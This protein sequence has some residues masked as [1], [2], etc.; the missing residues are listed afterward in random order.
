MYVGAA[1]VERPGNVV[2]CRHEHAVGMLVAESASDAH[3]FAVDGLACQLQGV[4]LHGVLGDGGAVTPQLTERVE[5]GAEGDSALTAQ[6]GD[7][8]F[9][10]GSRADHAVDAHFGAADVV[11]FLAQPL[12]DGG[13]A[14]DL[15]LHQL[16]LRALQLVGSGK[17]VTGV[18]PEGSTR[19]GDHRR[20][21]RAV[22]TTDPLATLPM[23]GHIFTLVRIGTGEDE[24]A[25]VLAAHQLPQH[26]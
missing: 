9:H 5:V 6:V 22:E 23:V 3:Q 13:C 7:E 19:H 8:R 12:A 26:L 4:N 24:C 20:T 14:L 25:Q 1:Q 16:V 10:L 15:Q 11:Q 18:G 21:G 17:E 2:E